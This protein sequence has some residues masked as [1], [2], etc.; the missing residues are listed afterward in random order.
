MSRLSMLLRYYLDSRKITD[1][2][3]LF[4]LLFCDDVEVSLSENVLSHVLRSEVYL[5]NQRANV[6]ELADILEL[7]LFVQFHVVLLLITIDLFN[8]IRADLI[9]FR[10]ADQQFNELTPWANALALCE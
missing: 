3:S 1:R 8:I 2:D 5:D 7:F 6:N 9:D 4:Q 10:S